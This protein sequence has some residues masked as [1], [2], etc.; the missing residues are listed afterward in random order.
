MSCSL[1]KNVS[2]SLCRERTS[3][4]MLET[5]FTL[6]FPLTT[7]IHRLKWYLLLS[8]LGQ[9]RGHDWCQLIFSEVGKILSSGKTVQYSYSSPSY[10][11]V[12]YIQYHS[13]K[14]YGQAVTHLKELVGGIL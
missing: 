6:Y 14:P 7:Y 10:C 11:I 4:L 12:L 2:E 5:S 8:H 1:V 9:L 13:I 3:F